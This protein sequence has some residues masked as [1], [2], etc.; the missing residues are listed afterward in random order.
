MVKPLS[1]QVRQ[2]LNTQRMSAENANE[3]GGD[4]GG[5]LADYVR[6]LQEVEGHRPRQETE[7]KLLTRCPRFPVYFAKKSAIRLLGERCRS[8]LQTLA[9][10]RACQQCPKDKNYVEYVV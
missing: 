10:V 5:I 6:S 8:T 3:G 2:V 7:E 1:A 9:I 4:G